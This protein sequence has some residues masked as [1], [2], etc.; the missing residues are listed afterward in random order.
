MSGTTSPIP[1]YLRERD[2]YEMRACSASNACLLVD[3][4]FY[5]QREAMAAIHYFRAY[6]FPYQN[7]G[8]PKYQ[9]GSLL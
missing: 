8:F 7:A 2:T 4:Q 3:S 6:Q 9:G 5:Q 1:A